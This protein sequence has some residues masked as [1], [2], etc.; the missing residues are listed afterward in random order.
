MTKITKLQAVS[1]LAPNYFGLYQEITAYLGRVLQVEIALHQS[2]YDPLKDTLLFKDQI[3]LAFICG[4]P[5]IRYSQIAPNQLQTLVAPVMQSS[6]YGDCPVYYA[7]V[8]VKTDS[9]IQKFAD[10]SGKT[11]CYNDPGSNSG[12]HLLWRWLS[13][14]K[15]PP[16]FWGKSLESGSHQRSIR[17]VVEGLAD[18]AAIDS[19]VLE[20]ELRDFPELSHHLRVVQIIGPSPM[21][22]LVTARRLGISLIQQMQLALLQPDAQLQEIMKQFS[23]KRFDAVKLENYR[24]LNQCQ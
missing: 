4:L 1:Y 8:I 23:V 3:D 9:N 19:V 7:D 16:N 13:E 22:P 24:V 5:L 12:Y 20:Q 11:F 17:W 2:K 14:E 10:L 21:P 15:Y 18:C 6:R